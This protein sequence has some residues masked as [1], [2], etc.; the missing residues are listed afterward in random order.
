MSTKEEEEETLRDID[1]VLRR[2]YALHERANGVWPPRF[3]LDIA[4]RSLEEA[5]A[6]VHE[7]CMPKPFLYAVTPA[8]SVLLY[9]SEK[10]SQAFSEWLR[11]NEIA[12]VGGSGSGSLGM[13]T[14]RY[15]F[16]DDECLRR[17]LQWLKDNDAT[18]YE[19]SELLACAQREHYAIESVR[20]SE[21]RKAVMGGLTTPETA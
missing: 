18:R 14:Y 15:Y 11:K 13:W 2:L 19:S 21:V 8:V 16:T 1:D 7:D 20:V 4:I 10:L 9:L 3:D 5:R 17:V 12:F 6:A